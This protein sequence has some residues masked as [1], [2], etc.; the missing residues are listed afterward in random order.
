VTSPGVRSRPSPLP[1]MRI[2]IVSEHYYPQLGGITAHAYGQ[3]TELARRGHEVTLVTPSLLLPPRTVD[4]APPREE[5]FEI[6]R[7]G[8]AYP[9]YINASEEA[10]VCCSYRQQQRRVTGSRKR[11][12][13]VR[14]DRF[15]R[16]GAV[17]VAPLPLSHFAARA[18][19]PPEPKE[20]LGAPRASSRV[21]PPSESVVAKQ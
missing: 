4:E 11:L 17:V 14:P 3:A 7:V 6:V 2:A 5:L 13:R 15:P 19:R 10:S 12:L 9:F 1:R 20:R 21:H 8:R 16:A 18:R